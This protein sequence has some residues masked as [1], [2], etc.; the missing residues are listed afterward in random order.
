MTRYGLLKRPGEDKFNHGLR[1]VR[2]WMVDSRSWMRCSANRDASR[3]GGF[4]VAGG[5]EKKV[6]K[7]EKKTCQPS[8]SSINGGA[9]R[10]T[11]LNSRSK[12][13]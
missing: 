13:L 5:V 1:E 10:Q 2:D 7:S 11:G 12:K 3:E 4:G 9:W 8:E 6:K